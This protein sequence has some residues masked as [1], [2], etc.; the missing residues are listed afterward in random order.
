MSLPAILDLLQARIG[1]DPESL[2]SHF[3]PNIVAGRMRLLGLAEPAAYL[4]RLSASAEELDTLVDEVL[5]PETW[6]FRGGW[7]FSFLAE[8]IRGAVSTLPPGRVFRVLSAPCSSG[9]EPCSL[10]IALTDLQVP[11][12]TWTIDALDLSRRSLN[13]AEKGYYGEGSFRGTDPQLRTRYFRQ[14]GNGWEIDPTLRGTVRFRRE[15]LMDPRVLADEEPFDLIFCRNL[16]IYLHPA[17]RAQ[18]LA[19]LDRLL[20]PQGLVCMGHAEPL[21]LLDRRFQSTG[22]AG[23]F[24]F[25]RT[26]DNPVPTSAPLAGPL[27]SEAPKRAAGNCETSTALA[28]ATDWLAQARRQADTGDLVGA[29]ASCGALLSSKGPSADVYSLMGVLHH[30]Q[31]DK[32]EA[33]SCFRKALYLDAEHAEALTHLMLLHEQ[34][35]NDALARLLRRRLERRATGGES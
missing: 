25:R 9:E 34:D 11:R 2:D 15:N 20:A 31:H 13:R 23:H 5:V 10:A 30:A 29:L 19:T 33:V 6:F 28:V 18:V 32:A 3:V 16:L 22:P 4:A 26:S 35:G 24:L 17:A 27:R 21:R 14:S 7:L 12:E 1:L 8:H